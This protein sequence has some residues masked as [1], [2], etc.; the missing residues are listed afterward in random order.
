MPPKMRDNSNRCEGKIVMSRVSENSSKQLHPEPGWSA[1]EGH[2]VL[3]RVAMD[4]TGSSAI[5]RL[6][7][8]ERIY[9][10]GWCFDER[11]PELLGDCFT[12]DGVWEGRIMGETSVGPF[13]GRSAI[14]QWLSD[15]WPQQFDQRRHMFTNVTVDD[16]TATTATAHAYL[17]LTRSAGAAMISV[18]VGPY[19]LSM[20]KDSGVWRI[21]HLI[22][23]FD[24]PF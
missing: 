16:L 19:R 3:K 8:T 6:L 23:G 1:R 7:I 18:T 21:A 2:S 24:V 20:A 9:R 17:L 4:A 22:G 5:D 12:A 15:F 14:V 11:N 13:E 10:Y